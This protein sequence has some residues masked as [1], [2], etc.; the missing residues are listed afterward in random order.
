M[1]APRA[2]R[3]IKGPLKGEEDTE[4]ALD[5]R[6]GFGVDDALEDIKVVTTNIVSGKNNQEWIGVQGIHAL[7]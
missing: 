4:V 7:R 5:T 3:P 2:S 1:Y 6:F